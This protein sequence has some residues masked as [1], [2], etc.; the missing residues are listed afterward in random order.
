[1]ILL[2]TQSFVWLAEN[3]DRLGKAARQIEAESDQVFVSAISLWEIGLLISRNRMKLS[4][5][6]RRW[7]EVATQNGRATI[8]PVSPD[9]AFEAGMLPH[10][11]HG[12]PGDRIVLATAIE[13]NCPVITSDRR[14]LDYAGAG[15]VQAIDARR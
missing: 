8:H 11:P 4:R 10:Y 1:M 6:Y 2:D 14:M 3:N 12:D 9:I 7:L 15:H 5:P 13:L